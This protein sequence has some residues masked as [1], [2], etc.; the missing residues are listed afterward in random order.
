MKLVLN[1]IPYAGKDTDIVTPPDPQVVGS[2]K[3]IYEHGE[4]S[5][6]HAATA[7]HAGA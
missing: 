7:H 6:G 1:T 5:H 2:A 3:T 4:N